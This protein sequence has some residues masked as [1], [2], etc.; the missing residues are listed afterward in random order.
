M[1]PSEAITYRVCAV[2]I[3]GRPHTFKVVDEG[4]SEYKCL[5]TRMEKTTGDSEK[6]GKLIAWFADGAGEIMHKTYVY[7]LSD[8]R[9]RLENVKSVTERWGSPKWID[10]VTGTAIVSTRQ[11]AAEIAKKF[12]SCGY[13]MYPNDSNR[14]HS[15]EEFLANK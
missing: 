6:D 12:G 4:G 11:E 13:V 8:G 3:S 10:T 15:V 5:L 14:P 2:E 1:S 7:E 9:L